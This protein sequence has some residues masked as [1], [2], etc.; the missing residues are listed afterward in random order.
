MNSTIKFIF[1]T[2]EYQQCSTTENDLNLI[3]LK[4]KIIF[5]SFKKIEN[6]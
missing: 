4:F 2:K 6:Y 3:N 5:Q 1:I